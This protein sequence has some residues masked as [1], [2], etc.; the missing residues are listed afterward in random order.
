LQPAN[1]CGSLLHQPE[2]AQRSL[3]RSFAGAEANQN[4]YARG[5]I[6]DDIYILCQ[7]W[8]FAVVPLADGRRQILNVLMAGDMFSAHMAF[9]GRLD[10]S[11]HALTAVRYSRINRDD[12][13]ATLSADPQ[14][15]DALT[16]ICAGERRAANNMIIDL[17]RRSADERIAHLIL[18]ITGRIGERSIIREQTYPFPLRQQ[19]IAD[20]SGLTPVHV[21]RVLG[22]FRQANLI[23]LSGGK[24]RINNIEELRRIGLPR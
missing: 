8:A 3:R 22:K 24:L 7:G 15:L 17:G 14:I 1:F 21:S 9:E 23:D 16:R 10:F 19:D 6:S 2:S 11:V 13:K 4:I 12:L 18:T 5:E 20:M